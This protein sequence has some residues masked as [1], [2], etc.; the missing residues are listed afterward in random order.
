MLVGNETVIFTFSAS[1]EY[2]ERPFCLEFL[3]LGKYVTFAVVM[4]LFYK[5]L[6]AEAK[7]VLLYNIILARKKLISIY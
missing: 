1:T 7:N 2:D 5:I 6:F 4:I 3:P